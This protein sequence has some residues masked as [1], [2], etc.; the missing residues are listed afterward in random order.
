[1]AMNNILRAIVLHDYEFVMVVD[2]SSGR[3]VKYIGNDAYAHIPGQGDHAAQV[4]AVAEGFVLPEDREEYLAKMSLDSIVAMLETRKKPSFTYRRRKLSGGFAY[5]KAN[6]IYASEDRKS[7]IIAYYDD[8]EDVLAR[9]KERK[10]MELQDEGIRFMAH[11]LC[12]NFIV[13]DLESGGS[14]IVAPDNGNVI[15]KDTFKEQIDWFA[16]NIVAPEEREAYL[17]YFNLANLV[18]HTRRNNGFCTSHWTVVYKDG[19]HNCIIAT[20][21]IKDP[22]D[23]EKEFLFTY[24]QDITRLKQ[25]ETRN[26][27]LFLQSRR[28]PLTGLC[29][30]GAAKQDIDAYLR[31]P[32]RDGEDLL[33][34]LDIDFFKRF[35]DDFGHAVGDEVLIFMAEAMRGAFRKEDILCRWGGDE[36]LIFMKEFCSLKAVAQRLALLRRKMKHFSSEGRTLPVSLS[37]GGT[38][39]G[40]TTRGL[41]ELFQKADTAL[42]TVKH[43]GR[44]GLAVLGTDGARLV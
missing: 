43:E 32:D 27:E 30:R 26:K 10:K 4:R 37:I 17:R 22:T 23:P 25:M 39:A 20:T 11:N 36:F 8:T 42:Y 28:D 9:R 12:E 18:P 6:F 24:A 19:R 1:M 33:L 3:Y 31:S 2:L 41:E 35:N 38:M 14:A 34:I 44:D 15:A 21:L 29:N 13:V 7:V 5:L 16:E 40:A